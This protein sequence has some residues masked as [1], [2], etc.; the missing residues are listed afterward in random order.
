VNLNCKKDLKYRRRMR[1]RKAV[2][3]TSVRPRLS[4]HFSGKHMYAQCV[5]DNLG[6][7]LVYLSTVAKDPVRRLRANV[8]GAASFGEAFGK[9]A[10]DAGIVDIVFD[11]DTKRYHGKVKAFA[12]AVRSVG[13]KF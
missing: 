3:G 12:D 8:E 4:L 1:I 9:V 7:T 13:V 5:D 11:R 6:R 10:L 2:L